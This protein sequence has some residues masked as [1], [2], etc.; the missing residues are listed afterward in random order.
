MNTHNLVP[1]PTRWARRLKVK[2]LESFLILKECATLSE[3]AQRMHMTQSAMSHW[4]IELESMAGVKLVQRGR[5]IRL[6]PAG[7]ALRRLAIRIL[8]DVARTHDELDYLARGSAG[9]LQIGTVTT[10]LA[11][12]IPNAIMTFQA[13]HPDVIIRLT[14]GV[15]N[16]LL[17]GLEKR[18]LDLFIGLIDARAY[19]PHLA[20]EVLFEDDFVAIVGPAHPLAGAP[21]VRWSDLV[22]Y[23][24]IMPPPNTLMRS[25]V[26]AVLLD[27]G[28]AG[29]R[30]R[31][32]TGSILTISSLLRQSDWV[33]VC[34]GALGT[35]MHQAG[36]L[37]MLPLRE[38]FGPVGA[39]YRETDDHP[40]I[41]A[42]LAALRRQGSSRS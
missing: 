19:A 12:L 28:G 15:F 31:V 37:H 18:D 13:E 7:D 3:A 8:G 6:T 25:R 27:R 36:L 4:L 34:S 33:S 1:D 26:D 16:Q 21:R 23:P 40:H 10:G 20:H 29:I 30:P 9:G 14:E 39:V 41:G 5:Q 38:S 2:H 35:R 17:T 42:F 11:E 22:D 24:W 32:E